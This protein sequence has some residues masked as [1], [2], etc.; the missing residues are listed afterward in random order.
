MHNFQN[1]ISIT[2]IN[3]VCLINRE[4]IEIAPGFSSSQ[5]Q[6][7]TQNK[8]IWHQNDLWYLLQV[9]WTLVYFSCF[10]QLNTVSVFLYLCQHWAVLIFFIFSIVIVVLM[11]L[12]YYWY[13]AAFFMLVG[14]LSFSCEFEMHFFIV[15]FKFSIV[16]YLPMLLSRIS[17]I[18]TFD[19]CMKPFPLCQKICKFFSLFPV[20]WNF[21]SYW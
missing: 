3:Q 15:H 19:I 18:L 1:I 7:R 17:F 5:L 10:K 20:L 9:M 21:V 6:Y 4:W 13:R 14:K 12:F 11:I 8:T 2:L 16:F